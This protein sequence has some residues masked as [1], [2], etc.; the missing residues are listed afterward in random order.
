[1]S[2]NVKKCSVCDSPSIKHCLQCKCC[3]A[4]SHLDNEKKNK[5]NEIKMSAEE[6]YEFICKVSYSLGTIGIEQYSTQDGD[7]LR[8]AARTLYLEER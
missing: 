3:A 5:K 2:S 6:A 7:K 1:M 8:E 4:G